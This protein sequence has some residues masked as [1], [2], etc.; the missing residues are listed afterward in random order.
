MFRFAAALATVAYAADVQV[1][2][3]KLEALQGWDMAALLKSATKPTFEQKDSAQYFMMDPTLMFSDPEVPTKGKTLQF[4]MGGMWMM[5]QHVDHL[6][7]KCKLDGIPVYN[8]NFDVKEDV[9]DQWTHVIPFDVPR[10]APSSSYDV[11]FSAL[12]TSGKDAVE[13][14]SIESKFHL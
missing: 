7:F 3:E 9:A 4:H 1:I 5:P 10:I 8:E 11:T 13:L 14:F 6:N 2:E 12:T